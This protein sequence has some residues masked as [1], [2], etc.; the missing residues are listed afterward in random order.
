VYLLHSY[1]SKVTCI[2]ISITNSLNGHMYSSVIY[3]WELWLNIYI[4]I[5]SNIVTQIQICFLHAHTHT[6]THTHTHREPPST[7]STHHL[8]RTAYEI[9]MELC[10]WG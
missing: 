2:M 3:I 9:M 1:G 8:L 4:L 7:C 10:G 5:P 6:H